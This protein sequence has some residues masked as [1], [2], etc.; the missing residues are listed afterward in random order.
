MARKLDIGSI[1]IGIPSRYPPPYDKM[2]EGRQFRALGDAA[3]LT[4]FGVKLTTLLPGYQNALRHWHA[5]ED[6]F[7][8]MLSG[9]LILLTEAGEDVLAAGDAV[10]FPA[11]EA[12]GHTLINRFDD[13]AVYIEIGS[14]SDR[15]RITYPDIG[16]VFVRGPD[17][18]QILPMEHN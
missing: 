10:G 3:G 5:V 18:E 9:Q 14:R 16:I 2:V 13:P 1:P 4:Q 6:E 7:I 8:Y 11:G 17:G 15:E 12:D